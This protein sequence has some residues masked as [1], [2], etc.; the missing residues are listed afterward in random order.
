MQYESA[1]LISAGSDD[2][3]YIGVD[4]K[5]N[6]EGTGRQ[7]VRLTSTASYT[8]GLFILNLAHMPGSICGTWPAFWTLGS[9]WPNHGKID[10][11]EGVNLQTNDAMTLHTS[12]D[13]TVRDSGFT[14][15]LSISNC[16]V[17]ATGQSSNAGCAITSASASSYGTGFNNA[18]GG[19]YAMEWTR[20]YIRT[21]FFSRDSVPADIS[22][23]GPNPSGWGTPAA[24]FEG[25]C[26]IDSHFGSHQIVFDITFC[27]YWTGSVWESSGC[28]SKASTCITYVQNNPF[29]FADTYWRVNS[30]KIYESN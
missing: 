5:N 8:H 2:S 20:S 21:F 7:S 25:D 26:H 27:G 4:T 24:L 13:C 29:A 17:N 12:N 3:T 30:L 23:G 11:I 10:I 1:G 6:A 14:G 9:D 18:S 16:Y 19:V 15:T 22:G 28:S